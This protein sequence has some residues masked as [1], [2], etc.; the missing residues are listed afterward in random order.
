[1]SPNVWAILRGLAY[2]A[3]IFAAYLWGVGTGN[4]QAELA[5]NQFILDEYIQGGAC[6]QLDRTT[7]PFTNFTLATQGS[8]D[9]G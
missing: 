9:N 5:C 8:K 6:A 7:N 3:L 2:A 4:Y 1:M